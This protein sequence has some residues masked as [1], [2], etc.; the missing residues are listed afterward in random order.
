MSYQ[1][2]DDCGKRGFFKSTK[3]YII[4]GPIPFKIGYDCILFALREGNKE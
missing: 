3:L 1:I 2:H 4:L